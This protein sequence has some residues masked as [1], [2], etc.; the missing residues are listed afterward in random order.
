MLKDIPG[1]KG[2]YKISD[3][4]EVLGLKRTVTDVLG[5]T[6]TIYPRIL[7]PAYTGRGYL[8]VTLNMDGKGTYKYIHQLVAEAFV[9]K[10]EVPEGVTLIVNHKDGDKENNN[11]YNL[12]WVTYSYNNLHALDNGLRHGRGESHYNSKLTEKDVIYIKNKIKNGCEPKELYK[13]FNVARATI[14]D[15]AKGK[16]WKQVVV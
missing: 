2:Y 1:F 5:H 9:E 15:I 13:E 10:P 14:L 12:E 11:S 7:S 8:M 16:T 3:T 4:G 6:Y